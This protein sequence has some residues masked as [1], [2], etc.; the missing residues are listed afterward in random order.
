MRGEK[1]PRGREGK[2]LCRGVVGGSKESVKLCL[3]VVVAGAKK[4]DCWVSGSLSSAVMGGL[5]DLGSDA[6]DT[7]MTGSSDSRG[8]S[9]FSRA[10]CGNIAIASASEI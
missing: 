10:C 1:E 8:I 3:R 7:A 9:I 4:E 2:I 6:S 5:V